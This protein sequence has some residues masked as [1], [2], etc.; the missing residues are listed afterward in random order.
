MPAGVAAH[1]LHPQ[2]GCPHTLKNNQ[3][4]NASTLPGCPQV[5]ELKD[6][7][8][9]ER[10]LALLQKYDP[11]KRPL[12]FLREQH[13]LAPAPHLC[14]A[15]PAPCGLRP[16]RWLVRCAHLKPI[17]PPAQSPTLRA[18]AFLPP[19][20]MQTTRRRARSTCPAAACPARLA[21]RAAAPPAEQLGQQPAQRDLPCKVQV[22]K[23]SQCS[24]SSI[25]EPQGPSSVSRGK[26][27]HS[28]PLLCC[29]PAVLVLANHCSTAP[30]E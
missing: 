17:P 26:A 13:P 21:P 2:H 18:S 6:S 29:M 25:A 27:Y 4:N 9:Y 30:P 20:A 5:S 1:G 11:G 19:L 14:A 16:A 3:S 12:P 10:T 22:Q 7:T 8:R 28:L 23:C 15:C 24:P